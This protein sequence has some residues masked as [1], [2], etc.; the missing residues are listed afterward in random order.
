MQAIA[1]DNDNGTDWNAVRA[2][3]AYAEEVLG[4]ELPLVGDD[5]NRLF[6][7]VIEYA[8]DHGGI[9]LDWLLYGDID[10]LMRRAEDVPCPAGADK[11]MS[12]PLHFP[13]ERNPA[14]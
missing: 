5:P 3:L 13:L 12:A 9:T 1:N 7:Q 11:D 2:R 6:D 10:A 8:G 14:T 4:L